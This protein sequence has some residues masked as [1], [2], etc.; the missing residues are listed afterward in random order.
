MNKI[1]SILLITILVIGTIALTSCQPDQPEQPPVPD[2]HVHA[3]EDTV[4]KPTCSAHGF[5]HHVCTECGYENYDSFV[6]PDGVTHNYILVDTVDSTCTER[7]WEEY[8]CEWCEAETLTPIFPKHTYG[9]WAEFLAPTCTEEGIDRR[10]CIACDDVTA[11]EVRSIAA[12]GHAHE[13]TVTEP[14]CLDKGF[15]TYVCHCGDTYVAD[16]TEA[17]GHAFGDWTLVT[18]P[19]CND[20]GLEERVCACGAKEENSIPAGH[21]SAKEI[22]T[23]VDPTCTTLGYTLVTCECCNYSHT[24]NY[25]EVI[26]HVYGDW[27]VVTPAT[28]VTDGMKARNCTY[29]CGK[30]ETEIIPSAHNTSC[31]YTA[32]TV[33]PTCTAKGYDV[34]ACSTKGCTHT[35]KT[36]Y[37]SKLP[38]TYGEWKETLAPTCTSEGVNTRTCE[39][40]AKETKPIA[41][42]PHVYGDWVVT[43][44]TCVATGIQVKTCECGHQISEVLPMIAH[45]YVATVVDPTETNTGYTVHTCVCG[46]S[47]RDTFVSAAGSEGIVIADGVVTHAGTFAGNVLV[48]PYSYEGKNVTTIADQVFINYDE[49]TTV[50]LTANITSIEAAAFAY[51]DNLDTIIFEGTMDQWKAISKGIDWDAGLDSY[52]VKCADGDIVVK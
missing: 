4:V 19:T 48:I 27:D 13:G 35:Y 28:C 37:V 47:Y 43:P 16:E 42:L 33:A 40:G 45:V 26:P 31:E 8:N 2:V 38:H 20:N 34:I 23:V 21:D 36:N 46:K 32:E 50:Y 24:E 49:I 11:Y 44:A 51:S 14:T 5:T 1:F 6:E 22:R 10:E 30:A 39:C 29:G 18:A 41:I 9:E 17:K 7:G 3:F 25:V 15:T 12:K 52:T